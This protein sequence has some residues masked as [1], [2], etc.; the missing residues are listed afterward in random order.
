MNF[1]NKK[2]QILGLFQNSSNIKPFW[3]LASAT[4][5]SSRNF[6]AKKYPWSKK[7]LLRK[8]FEKAS[9][10][11]SRLGILSILFFSAIPS[12]VFS[13]GIG[14][15]IDS[16]YKIV[17]DRLI[18]LAFALCVFYFFWGV[19]QYIKGLDSEKEIKNSKNIMVWGIVG[20]FI[21]FS[22]WGIIKLIQTEINL[23]IKENVGFS[24][25]N[26]PFKYY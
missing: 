9:M 24:V 17:D 8:N 25:N 19:A 6:L 2:L 10:F 5:A 3:S 7:V 26:I 21:V 20:L 23:P 1:L 13:A 4:G 22:V 16:S 11:I 12:K 14:D 18:P 15:F